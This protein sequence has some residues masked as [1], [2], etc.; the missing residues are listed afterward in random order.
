MT[1]NLDDLL[2]LSIA[3][4]DR[5]Q[6]VQTGEEIQI[7]GDLLQERRQFKALLQTFGAQLATARFEPRD[8]DFSVGAVVSQDRRRHAPRLFEQRKQQ[9]AG[10]DGRM[11][12][13]GGTLKRQLAHELRGRTDTN[14]ASRDR[15]HS[16]QRARPAIEEPRSG[17][18]WRRASLAQ[19][20]PTRPE[21]RQTSARW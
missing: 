9:I 11:A 20:D 14:L 16:A 18:R 7:G 19:T 2:D 6:L 15:R 12:R 1:Q 21:Q 13:A 17:S 8:E 10:V 3:T 4:E 5:R